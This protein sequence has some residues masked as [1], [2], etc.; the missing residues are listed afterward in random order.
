MIQFD[1]ELNATLIPS[2]MGPGK[3]IQ[4]KVYGEGPNGFKMGVLAIE[5]NVTD[6]TFGPS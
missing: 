3:Q 2:E 5:G 1:M 6:V 4:A